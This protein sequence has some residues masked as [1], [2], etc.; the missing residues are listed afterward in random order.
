MDMFIFKY[1][2]FSVLAKFEILLTFEYL[3]ESQKKHITYNTA[4]W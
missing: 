4:M 1:L 3:F 2:L